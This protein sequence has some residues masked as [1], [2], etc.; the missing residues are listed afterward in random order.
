MNTLIEASPTEL[1]TPNR[2][3]LVPRIRFAEFYGTRWQDLAGANYME[4]MHKLAGGMPFYDQDRKFNA[5]ERLL[6]HQE[7]VLS[8]SKRGFVPEASQRDP[9]TISHSS[10]V[11]A[12]AH[13]VS[14]AIALGIDTI[15]AERVDSSPSLNFSTDYKGLVKAGFSKRYVE[16]LLLTALSYRRKARFVL[17]FSGAESWKEPFQAEMKSLGTTVYSSSLKLSEDGVRRL[18]ELAYSMNDWW[19]PSY[20]DKI[21]QEKVP[22]GNFPTSAF[23]LVYE[24]LADVEDVRSLKLELRSKLEALGMDGR[25]LH[26]SDTWL[27]TSPVLDILLSAGGRFF[28]NTV[29]YGAERGLIGR[30]NEERTAAGEEP[31]DLTI[32]GSAVLEL[33]GLRKARDID[34]F[35]LKPSPLKNEFDWGDRNPDYPQAD[36]WRSCNNEASFFYRGFYFQSLQE[37]VR[38]QNYRV[39]TPKGQRDFRLASAMLSSETDSR[40]PRSEA[41]YIVLRRVAYASR[42][43]FFRIFGFLGRNTPNWLR[44]LIKSALGRGTKAKNKGG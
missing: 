21:C 13:R 40:S 27:D 6:A 16:S 35:S 2:L 28:L 9:I 5:H 4:F 10:D 43:Y 1:V 32:A 39:L 41:L 22:D 17:L 38:L 3:D 23:L 19:T 30:L 33:H 44:D 29:P 8:F 37:Y 7:L 15:L 36:I 11:L 42:I 26:G 24:P 18:I 14:V 31:K 20:I 34:Y 12:G 25:R